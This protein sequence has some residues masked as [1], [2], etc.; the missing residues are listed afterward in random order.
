MTQTYGL[1]L[2]DAVDL[3][4]VSNVVTHAREWLVANAG[5][6][7]EEVLEALLVRMSL[8]HNMLLDLSRDAGSY[9]DGET[10]SWNDS[11]ERIKRVIATHALG[12]PVDEAW[13]TSVQRKLASQ[14]PP[15]PIVEFSFDEAV[16]CLRQL[17]NEAMDLTKLL[18]FESAS[19][20][21]V[22]SSC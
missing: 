16:V 22:S 20:T 19:N 11:L 2:L 12:K 8:R 5:R 21:M 15:R 10:L 14:V 13:S 17:C 7:S 3:A 4:V 9:R 6:F 18:Y 1:P